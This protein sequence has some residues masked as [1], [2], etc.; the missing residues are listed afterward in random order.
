MG[1][2]GQ[3]QVLHAGGNIWA[4]S[5]G[6]LKQSEIPVSAAGE[7]RQGQQLL[8]KVIMNTPDEGLFLSGLLWP[9]QVRNNHMLV[10]SRE[11]VATGFTS[12]SH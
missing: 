1:G 2:V 7:G 4:R 5:L 10:F 12:S 9:C 3:Q 6:F 11:A 8:S